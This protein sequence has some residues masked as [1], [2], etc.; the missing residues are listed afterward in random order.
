MKPREDRL[1]EGRGDLDHGGEGI[2]LCGVVE[3]LRFGD[4][5]E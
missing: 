1:E 5:S 3:R 4:G 2:P